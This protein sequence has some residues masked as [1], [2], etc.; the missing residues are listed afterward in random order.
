[1]YMI[2]KYEWMQSTLKT[3]PF[4]NSNENAT[5]RT[6]CSTH[7]PF[8]APANDLAWYCN[9]VDVDTGSFC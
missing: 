7:G 2:E 5:T 1:M 6:N 4:H 8:P 9:T 3:A